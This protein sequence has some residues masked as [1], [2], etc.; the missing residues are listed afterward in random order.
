MGKKGYDSIR[1]TNP[2][3]YLTRLYII[4]LS[5]IALFVIMGQVLIQYALHKQQE[6]SYIINVAGR[7]RML[8]Q[9]IS[10]S[11]LL[12]Q[13]SLKANERIK[14]KNE[15]KNAFSIWETFH[16]GLSRGNKEIGLTHQNSEEVSQLFVAVNPYFQKISESAKKIIVISPEKPL[17][18]ESVNNINTILQY[19][20]GFLIGMDDIVHQYQVEAT[21]KVS[22]VRQI[23]VILLS[24]TLIVLLLEGFFVFRPFAK[25]IRSTIDEL[26]DTQEELEQANIGLEEKVRKR[27]EEI[28]KKNLEL[29]FKNEE[30]YKKNTDLDT[31]VYTASHD[32]KAPIN[33]IEGLIGQLSFHISESEQGFIIGMMKESVYKFKSVIKDLAETGKEQAEA[34]IGYNKVKFSEVF[35]EIKFS[36]HELIISSG[37]VI[38]EDF[39]G[40]PE[41]QFAKRSI[42]SIMYNLISNAIKYCPVDRKPE[43]NIST[44]KIQD[45]ILLEVSDNGI[46]IKEENKQK[47]FS[48]YERLAAKKERVFDNEGTG[49]GMALVAKIVDSNGG[50]IEIESTPGK[51]ST[52]RVYLKNLHDASI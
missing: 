48:M 46:G 42:R 51:G 13:F 7:Q 45:Y 27:T 43:I 10:K 17:S 47:I 26:K 33:N 22:L 36:I 29:S 3:L 25:K 16:E 8:S 52:F 5:C 1:Y 9:K 49:V 39:S 2:S 28:N 6:D 30:L 19:E 35:N 38:H 44:K 20:D 32:L 4:A 14:Y 15:L 12:I 40:A 24:L 34:K 31:F 11:C 37:A 18:E 21:R 50:K 41:I 23:E